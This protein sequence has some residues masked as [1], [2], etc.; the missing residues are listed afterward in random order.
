M[1]GLEGGRGQE[2]FEWRR[3]VS[4]LVNIFEYDSFC[5]PSQSHDYRVIVNEH[6]GNKDFCALFVGAV[7]VCS[8]IC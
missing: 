7:R 6:L 5:F 3:L 1:G 4:L 2:E 8:I